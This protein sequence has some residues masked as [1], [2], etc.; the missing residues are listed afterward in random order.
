TRH[1]PTRG[2]AA[3]REPGAEA[4]RLLEAGQP[5]AA[6]R[7]LLFL[8]GD[9]G[10]TAALAGPRAEPVRVGRADMTIAVFSNRVRG[11]GHGCVVALSGSG[12]M[13]ATGW[14]PAQPLNGQRC[15]TRAAFRAAAPLPPGC[16]ACTGL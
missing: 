5:R 1:A 4:V 14:R 13:R 16:G 6:P 2:R 7:P 8:D 9:L 3:A 12:I 11:G 15:L 10:E